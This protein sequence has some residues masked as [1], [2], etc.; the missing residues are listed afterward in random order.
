[1]GRIFL[2]GTSGHVGG[3]LA[4]Y[5]SQHR[6][7]VISIN[8]TYSTGVR[9]SN[10]WTYTDLDILL[11]GITIG[12]N[13]MLIHSAS[14]IDYDNLNV[15]ISQ[16]NS[17]YFHQ[18]LVRFKRAGLRKVI[19]ISGAPWSGTC[20]T[21]INESMAPNPQ[22]IY[23][24]SKFYQEKILEL[25]DFRFYCSLRLSSPVSEFMT[26]KTLFY[27]FVE[28]AIRDEDIE[29]FGKGSRQQDYICLKDVAILINR[30]YRS[31]KWINGSYIVASGHAIS[32]IEL[33]EKVKIVLNSKSEILFQGEDDQ[34]GLKWLYDISLAKQNLKFKPRQRLESVILALSK[35]ISA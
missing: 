5:L 33:A 25:L 31:D 9:S 4:N 30:L 35:N 1:M 21:A 13:D 26:K 7:E 19:L 15:E 32:N 16:F 8:R 29:V 11:E 2:T 22:S 14:V 24:L 34:E 20:N 10:C 23:H 27:T 28:K 12:S 18:L 6:Y 3:Y 17:C